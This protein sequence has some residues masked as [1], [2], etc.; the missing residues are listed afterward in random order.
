ML[1][2]K[3]GENFQTS[4]RT[5]GAVHER[6]GLNQGWYLASY[7]W[8]LM[9]L[10]PKLTAKAS[11][12]EGGGKK[13]ARLQQIIAR[14]FLDMIMSTAAYEEKVIDNLLN[15]NDNA[16]NN[17]NLRSLADTVVQVNATSFSSGPDWCGNA[18]EVRLGSQTISSACKSAGGFGRRNLR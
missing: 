18:R 3:L 11:M 7:A 12:F 13:K 8:V 2:G 6:I 1:G 5:I 16:N 14:I 4:A 9:R 10:L 17:R 15:H